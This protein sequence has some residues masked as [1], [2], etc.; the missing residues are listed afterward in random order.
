[1]AAPSVAKDIM[2]THLVT[3]SPDDSLREAMTLMVESHVS[4][5][6]VVDLQNHCVGVLSVTDVLSLE[7]DQA[8][9]S[10]IE[11]VGS[12]FDPD[13]QSWENM[14]F[15]GAI[16]ELP[17]MTVAEV[18]TQDVVSVSP[19]TAIKDVAQMMVEQKIHRILV[20][21]DRKQIL[22]LIAALDLVQLVAE[23]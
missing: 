16:D 12:Y 17:E 15:A 8:E 1:M 14:R 23:S 10:D 11:E 2:Q 4:G 22:G 13:Q 5:L 18:M 20:L 19:E 9:N 6:P 7:A 21:D 3:V